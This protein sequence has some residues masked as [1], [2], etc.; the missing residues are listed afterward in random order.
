M[1]WIYL[2][3]FAKHVSPEGDTIDMKPSADP[4]KG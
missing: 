4:F 2:F 3:I 1:R